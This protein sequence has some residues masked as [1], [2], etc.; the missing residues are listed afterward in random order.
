MSLTDHGARKRVFV[1]PGDTSAD[2]QPPCDASDGVS[3]VVARQIDENLKL[4][5]RQRIEQDL[6]DDLQALVAQLRD[7][8]GRT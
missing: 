5:Y 3:P 6:P 1:P 2:R 7:G 4:L 8:G